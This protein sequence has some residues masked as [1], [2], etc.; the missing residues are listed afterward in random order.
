MYMSRTCPPE[1][2]GTEYSLQTIKNGPFGPLEVSNP[3]SLVTGEGIANGY[4]QAS[5]VIAAE[6]KIVANKV[7]VRLRPDEDV[8]DCV[9]LYS[10]PDVSQQVIGAGEVGTREEAAGNKGLIKAYAL[11]SNSTLQIK[12]CSLSQRR[13]K[14]GIEII[15]DGPEWLESLRDIARSSPEDLT[16]DSNVMNEQ[17]V[18]TDGGKHATANGLRE[19]VAGSIGERCALQSAEAKRRI[20][21]LCVSSLAYQEANAQECDTSQILSQGGFSPVS[22]NYAKV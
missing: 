13:R 4:A 12:G 20:Q 14:D 2:K 21:L 11:A 10:H 15:E 3:A 9:E 19:E 8:V 5:G 17:H 22:Y 16:T 7:E 1:Q 18:S 6:L